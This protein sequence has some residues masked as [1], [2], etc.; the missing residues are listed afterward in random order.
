MYFSEQDFQ[1]AIVKIAQQTGDDEDQIVA[2]QQSDDVPEMLQPDKGPGE[3]PRGEHEALT[4]GAERSSQ[5]EKAG[6]LKDAF[7]EFDSAARQT[8]AELRNLLDSYGRDSISSK[9]QAEQG[10]TKL[11]AFQLGAFV[12]EIA[13]IA[14]AQYGRVARSLGVERILHRLARSPKTRETARKASSKSSR[15][16]AQN[17][18]AQTEAFEKIRRVAPPPISKPSEFPWS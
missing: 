16:L 12:D 8:G 15:L 17:P 1:R 13:K 14:K 2:G 3:G 5:D 6:Q 7:T 11:S 9:A 4:T 10:A 18:E